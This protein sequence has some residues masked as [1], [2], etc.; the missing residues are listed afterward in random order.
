MLFSIK[1]WFLL[2]LA[3]STL[4]SSS[5]KST[6]NAMDQNSLKRVREEEE[7]EKYGRRVRRKVE[8][9]RNNFSRRACRS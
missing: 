6:S 3:Q 4:G 5:I 1:G 8:E 7:E 2:F 9:A